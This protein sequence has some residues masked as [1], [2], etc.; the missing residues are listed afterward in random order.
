[1]L[2]NK[3][4]SNHTFNFISFPL[5]GVLF[6]LK[7]FINPVSYSFSAEE[8]NTLLFRPVYNLLEGSLFLQNLVT[9]MLILI[10]ALLLLLINSKYSFHRK[11]TMITATLFVILAGGLT[12]IHALHPVY[13]GAVFFVLALNSLFSAYDQPKPFSAAFDS[14]FLLGIAVL[15][16][17]SLVVLF[18]AFFIGIGILSGDKRWREYVVLLIGFI[19][20]ILFGA[21]YSF[22]FDK[23]SMFIENFHNGLMFPVD[24][25]AVPLSVKVFTVL[26]GI[27]V[28]IGSY[29]ILRAYD[30]MKV[31]TRKYFI[32]FFLIFVGTLGALIFLPAVSHAILIIIIV[33][34]TFLMTNYFMFLKNKFWGEFMFST[35]LLFVL[36]VQIFS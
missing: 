5:L 3:F 17:Y 33:P 29:K 12:P 24:T 19:L 14:G 31:S 15:F 26:V 32:I 11:R 9:L 10:M 13:F 16:Y 18:P 22:Y 21:G 4:K 7:H 20:P 6:W 28:L 25:F 36:I 8:K 30:S 34:V 35:L 1:M 2:L 27:I 23:F